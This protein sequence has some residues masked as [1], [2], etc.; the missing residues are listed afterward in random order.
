VP[1]WDDDNV[2]LEVDEVGLGRRPPVTKGCRIAACGFIRR[3]G[4]Q[5]R[6]FEMKST[7]SSSLHRRTW[8][9][10]FVP[11]RRRRPLELM[12]ARG[13]PPGSSK[14]GISQVEE[15]R[16]HKIELPKKS[17]LRELRLTNSLSGMPSTSMI[18]ESCSCSFSPGKIGKPVYSSAKM[19]PKL[20]ISMAI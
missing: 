15:Q 14:D 9:S 6:H 17:F 7:N 5:T 4:S 2:D 12:T 16:L 1:R 8:A 19:Q 3:S 11:G 20:H 18:Q 10:V 13:A